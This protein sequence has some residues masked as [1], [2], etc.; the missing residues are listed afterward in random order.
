M[1]T[2]V[3]VVRVHE[4]L[5]EAVVGDLNSVALGLPN[6]S[7]NTRFA[8]SVEYML[9]LRECQQTGHTTTGGAAAGGGAVIG[10]AK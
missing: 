1:Q 2:V 9:I 7:E 10:A 3:R 5:L 8:K 4:K 6:V